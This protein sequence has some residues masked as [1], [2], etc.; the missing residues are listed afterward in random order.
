MT[1]KER[2]GGGETEKS[3]IY[4][5]IQKCCARKLL[6]EFKKIGVLEKDLSYVDG[7]SKRL[8]FLRNVVI[9]DMK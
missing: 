8:I 3:H 1:E 6:K 7:H 5:S 4:T 2:E 9:L